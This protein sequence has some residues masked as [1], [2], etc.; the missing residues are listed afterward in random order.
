VA[1]QDYVPQSGKI[2]DEVQAILKERN[3]A[4]QFAKLRAS[5]HPQAQFLWA[6][7]R[8]VFHYCA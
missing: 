5:S 2:A 1:K 6:I 4:Q 7:F 8:D 3:P